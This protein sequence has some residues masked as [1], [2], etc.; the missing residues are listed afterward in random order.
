M[1]GAL[2]RGRKEREGSRE[3]G[4]LGNDR[5]GLSKENRCAEGE[6]DVPRATSKYSTDVW[7]LL[8][9]GGISILNGDSD[10]W[11]LL[12][13]AYQ[14]QSMILTFGTCCRCMDHGKRN[15]GSVLSPLP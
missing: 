5:T 1:A 4:G 14:Y 9:V 7:D 15:E 11:S 3:G 10:P 2:Q 8:A 13:M 12:P 6:D